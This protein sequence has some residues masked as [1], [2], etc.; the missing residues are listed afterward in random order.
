MLIH[1]K[2]LIQQF[3]FRENIYKYIN[4]STYTHLIIRIYIKICKYTEMF[5]HYTVTLDLYRKY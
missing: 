2:I 3:G 5:Q 1:F 4:I